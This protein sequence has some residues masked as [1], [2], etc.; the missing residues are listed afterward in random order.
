MSKTIKYVTT[1]F[2]WGIVS[3]V[4]DAGLKFLS[5]PMLL[6]YFGNE[7]FALISLAMSVNAYMNLLDMGVNTGAIKYFSEW[8]AR[9]RYAIIHSVARTSLYFYGLIGIVNSILLITVAG[10]GMNLFTITIDQALILRDLFLILAFFSVINWSTSV[11]NQLLIA[12]E[13]VFYIHQVNIV[14]SL[15]IFMVIAITIYFELGLKNYFIL[16]ILVNSLT[17]IPFFFL[18][19]KAKLIT[20]LFLPADWKNFSVIL[21]YSLSII[22]MSVFQV[23]ASS[24][25]PI[26]LAIFSTNG[27][28]V[29]AEYRIMETISILVISIGGMFTSIFLPKTS[30][31]LLEN[32]NEK[33][34]SFAYEATVYTSIVCVILCFPIILCAKEILSV[35]VGKEYLYLSNWLILWIGTILIFLHSTPISSIILSTGKTRI[36]TVSTGI[37]C[38]VSLSVTAILCRQIGV[39]SAI[40]GFAIYIVIQMSF[41]YLYFNK[42]VLGLDSLKVFKAFVF[43]T[44]LGL[45]CMLGVYFLNLKL[46][47][48]VIQMLIKCFIWVTLYVISLL[49]TGIINAKL[50]LGLARIKT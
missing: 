7:N 21:K 12:N 40:I 13:S 23:S 20:S 29:V 28:I 33:I 4:F 2:L 46:E 30:K 15:M 47:N 14:K 11:L 6:T 37:S 43:P 22:L 39:G 45:V 10:F 36:L 34:Q 25:R 17:I 42:R 32:D 50:I 38:I 44:L 9:G 24:L 19:K 27:I 3:K 5:V 31:L 48:L 49:L 8:I 35:Y 18:V 41:Y 1:S 26:I 16:F